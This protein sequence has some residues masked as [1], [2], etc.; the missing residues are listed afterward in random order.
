MRKESLDGD[1]ETINLMP[2]L[3]SVRNL[4]ISNTP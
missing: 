1:A 4:E 2:I 3:L